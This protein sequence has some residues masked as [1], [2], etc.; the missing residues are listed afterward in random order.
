MNHNVLRPKP[1]KSSIKEI[2]EAR[3]E[4]EAQ[5][6]AQGKPTTEIKGNKQTAQEPVIVPDINTT[7]YIAIPQYNMAIAMRETCHN[8]DMYDT[9]NSLKEEGLKMPSPAQFIT[10]WNNVRSAAQG[11]LQ[12]QYAN[13][14]AVDINTA[15]DLWNYMSSTDRSFW[16]E[17]ICWT[18]LN[19]Q[20]SE[21][22]SGLWYI[23]TDLEVIGSGRGRKLKG[24][25]ETLEA[26]A[27]AD[28]LANLVFNDQGLPTQDSALQDY[29]Q[30]DNIYFWKPRNNRVARF[31]AGSSWAVLYCD[32]VPSYS[33]A[34]LGVFAC[35][36][37]TQKNSGGKK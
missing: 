24:K 17:K 26:H 25:R 15:R 14:S 11:N 21:D 3:K 4:L 12:L 19:A 34:S 37:G 36:E 20:F 8:K 16:G 23:E 29:R 6:E 5:E 31:C 2:A 27:D 10:H 32:W 7:K 9:L 30:G 1:L 35:A 18:W 33:N 13:G 22:G 28:R